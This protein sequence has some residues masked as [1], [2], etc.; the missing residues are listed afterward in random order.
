[1]SIQDLLEAPEPNPQTVIKPTEVSNIR[2]NTHTL[3]GGQHCTRHG[4]IDM[5]F[6]LR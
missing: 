6:A 2:R 1:M 4:L 5:E 3:R